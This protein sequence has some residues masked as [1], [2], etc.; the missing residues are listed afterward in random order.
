MQA[1]TRA[2]W[3]RANATA[4][5]IR[6]S[7][8]CA[9]R[10]SGRAEVVI[11][12][13]AARIGDVVPTLYVTQE[14]GCD[15]HGRPNLWLTTWPGNRVARIYAT[16]K[17]RAFGSELTCYSATICGRNYYGRGQGPG[18]Y[19]NLRAGKLVRPC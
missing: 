11:A 3:E 8:K 12:R 7:G 16:G 14:P 1:S 5:R 6:A 15:L 9:N 19:I 10:Y 18:M 2:L 4:E 13:H 17:V